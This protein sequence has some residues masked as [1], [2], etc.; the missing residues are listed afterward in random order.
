MSKL[1]EVADDVEIQ[2]LI[3]KGV[4]RRQE[5]EDS[6]GQMQKLSTKFVRTWRAKRKANKSM[7]LRRSRLVAREYRWLDS[8]REGLFSPSTSSSIVRLLPL[9]F[10]IWRATRPEE[11][12]VLAT[13]DI[14]DAFL[15][16]PQEYPV[17][18]GHPS[19]YKGEGKFI[20]LK[21][22][23]NGTTRWF[24]FYANFLREHLQVQSCS[25]CP[26]VMRT[27]GGPF[28]VHVDDNQV[29]CPTNWLQS[30]FIPIL[31]SRF[32]ISVEVAWQVGDQISFLKRLHT[33][34]ETGV[35]I[36]LSE[37]YALNM[38]KILG[39]RPSD[40][41]QTPDLAQFAGHDSTPLLS[42]ADGSKFRPVVG[43][44][45]YVSADSPDIAHA[46]R[47]GLESCCS[48][49]SVS[50]QHCYLCFA[51]RTW[52]PALLFFMV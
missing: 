24:D 18:A 30:A 13:I 38:A 10:C 21:C 6:A 33:I 16:V 46:V 1:D 32:E 40:R 51:L 25:V 50:P 52:N 8:T 3:A 12:I 47:D 39:A 14:K 19:D 49:D 15:E 11:Q 31:K 36:N 35:R 44:A 2:R 29:L 28:L 48:P 42:E 37:Q 43:V 17:I 4:I 45:L 20:F 7:Q 23:R 34:T 26:A 27:D 9:L 22:I 41:A 5:P